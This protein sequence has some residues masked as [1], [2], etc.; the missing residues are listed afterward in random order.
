MRSNFTVFDIEIENLANGKTEV[1]FEIKDLPDGWVVSKPNYITLDSTS[2]EGNTKAIVTIAVTPPKGFGYHDDEE[3]IQFKVTARYYAT[4]GKT[5]EQDFPLDL[6]VE[7][8]GFSVIGIEVPIIIIL[9]ICLVIF[10][11]IIMLK[12]FKK[13]LS[14]KNIISIN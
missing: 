14:F 5:I 11:V 1:V 3:N 7:S 8:R 6:N 12:K 4:T 13:F 10:I 9:L 2:Y